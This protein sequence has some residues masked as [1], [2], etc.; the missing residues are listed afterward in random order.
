[1]SRKVKIELTPYNAM[2]ILSFCREFINEN[3][4]EQYIFKAIK[5]AVDEMESEL[6]KSLTDEHWQEITAESA[7]NELIGKVPPIIKQ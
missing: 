6:A 3:T 1:M 4:P 7:I 5:E 2:H